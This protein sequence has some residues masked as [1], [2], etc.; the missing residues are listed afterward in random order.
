M[1]FIVVFLLF[2]KATL[3]YCADFNRANAYCAISHWDLTP[4]NNIWI[5][6]KGRLLNRPLSL[7]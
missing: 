1:I 5:I 7:V 6:K 3:E 2:C 4:M